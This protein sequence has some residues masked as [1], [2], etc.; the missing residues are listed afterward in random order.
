[1]TGLPV[2]LDQRAVHAEG[3]PAT[4]FSTVKPWSARSPVRYF[5]VSNSW[6]PSSPK[7][8]SMSTISWT[9]LVLSWTFWRASSLRRLEARVGLLGREGRGGDDEGEQRGNEAT[10]EGATHVSAS[11]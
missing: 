6:K 4:P 5:W 8:N 9:I 3:I 7:E 1:M 10:H 2:P 11:G